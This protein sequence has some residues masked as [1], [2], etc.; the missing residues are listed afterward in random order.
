MLYLP[1]TLRAMHSAGISVT[2]GDFAFFAAQ[3]RHVA[4]IG[5]KFGLR[6]QP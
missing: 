2:R 5:V 1:A 3:G 6:S 4:S